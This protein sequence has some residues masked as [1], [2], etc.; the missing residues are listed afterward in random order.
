MRWASPGSNIRPN[1]SLF[2]P[3]LLTH[4]TPEPEP[5]RPL[6]AKRMNTRVE[7]WKGDEN[8]GE[9]GKTDWQHIRLWFE[10]P[11]AAPSASPSPTFL[12]WKSDP[13]CITLSVLQLTCGSSWIRIAKPANKSSHHPPFFPSCSLPFFCDISSLHLAVPVTSSWL[14]F[15][16][17]NGNINHNYGL[18]LNRG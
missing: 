7:R 14:Y 3:H 13:L 1:P 11:A 17:R 6:E 5:Q 8:G 16:S 12:S 2:T 18:L 9:K 10:C 4:L 15:K